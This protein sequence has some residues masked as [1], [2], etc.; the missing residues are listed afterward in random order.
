MTRKTLHLVATATLLLP[1]ASAFADVT[2][3]A[4]FSDHMVLEKTAKVPF[5][6]KADPGE[7][8]TIT[9][10]EKTAT[11][12]AGDDGKWTT[13][14]D[15]SDSG[16]GPFAVKVQGKNEI[17]IADVLVGEV[18]VASG[19]SNME[20]TVK[21]TSNAEEAI[22]QSANPQIRQFLVKKSA[23]PAPT[24][25]V[26]GAWTVASP[27]TTGGFTAVGYY[28]AKLLNKEL[29]TPVGLINTSW[30]GTPSEAWT[31][32]EALQSVP[33]LKDASERLL[34]DVASFAER[35]KDFAEKFSAWLKDNNRVDQKADPAAF[36][37][38]DV[39]AEGW[40][41]VTLPGVITGKDLPKN[42]TVWLRRDI[43]VAEVPK[44]GFRPTFNGV[45]GFEAFYWNGE[46]ISEFTY[47]TAPGAGPRR[48]YVIPAA[49]IKQGKNV[50]AVR[51]Y[52]P[53]V[54]PAVKNDLP[55]FGKQSAPWLAKGETSF[56]DLAAGAKPAPAAPAAL[57][58]QSHTASYL[59]NGMLNPIIPYAIKGAIWY[60]G[61]T[62]AGRSIQYRTAFPLMITDWRTKWEQGD[63][64][65]YFVQLANFMGKTNTPTESG[66]AELREAQSQ[67]LKLA[68]TGQAV[69][70]DIGE[71]ADIHPRNKK[72]VGE[73][74]AQIALAKD[75]GQD[76]VYSGPVYKSLKVADGKAVLTFDHIGGGLVANPVPAKYDVNTGKKET[77]DLVR[78]S[79]NSE[80]EGFAIC[81]EDKQ[82]VWADAKIDGDTVVVWSDKVAKPVA[83]RYGWANNP[84]TNLYNKAGL[85][86]SPFR[87]DDFP[88]ATAKGTYY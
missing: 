19:Q 36:A 42:G 85:P 77:A 82:W 10:G 55:Q 38:V 29:K 31:S 21:N 51:I 28:F 16:P 18:W 81:G 2:L 63:F 11:T 26:E 88:A 87:T 65:F 78:N 61:E 14:L 3:P 62:N 83:V 71:S 50:A 37:G 43:D 23:L 6:G 47:E 7:K 64:P 67:T 86:A 33:E 44:N 58:P 66:W 12:T 54:P 27:E 4:I 57:P 73:R 52:A 68:N 41:P 22:A 25:F 53:S 9:L 60:Q 70:I 75:Y 8:V 13:S 69:I 32:Q 20:W 48:E 74:L 5:W 49:K 30:G 46:L 76:I 35:N 24:D 34:K 15:L 40:V 17:P 45:D 1:M 79:P 56:P 80:L 59:Y 39:S 84:N 72:D